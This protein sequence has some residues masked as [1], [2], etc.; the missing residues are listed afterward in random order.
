MTQRVLPL[1]GAVILLTACDS[2]PEYR[3]T[4]EQLGFRLEEV[5]GQVIERPAA[6]IDAVVGSRLCPTFDGWFAEDGATYHIRSDEADD[7]WLRA[8]FEVG[9]GPGAH[10]E[11]DAC[12]VLDAAGATSMSLRPQAC[13]LTDDGV[14]AFEADRLAVTS[15]AID[16][17]VLTYDDVAVRLIY[18]LHPGPAG[19]FGPRPERG[20]SEPLQVVAGTDFEVYLQPMS[21]GVAV[22]F[23]GGVASGVADGEPVAVVSTPDGSAEFRVEVDQ[24]FR[25]ELALPAGSL[26]GDEIVGV[27]ADAPQSLE[28]VVGYQPCAACDDGYGAPSYGLAIVRD[29]AGA[30]VFGA[31]VQWSTAGMAAAISSELGAYADVVAFDEPCGEG[32]VGV[33]K[34]WT[35]RASLGS[36]AAEVPVTFVCPDPEDLDRWA[37]EIV[38]G[39]H[40]QDALGCGC[41]AGGGAVAPTGLLV[42]ALGLRRR[43][44]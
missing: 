1:L 22:A 19:S 31:P 12:L 29:A 39:E 3:S 5:P 17:L 10:V 33:A 6:G 27:G 44:C 28:I 36:L 35:L 26:V 40:E 20:P 37:V 13:A 9:P 11:D 30:R 42:L 38:D 18:D 4:G 32:Q 7:G 25:V 24:R 41:T 16:D 23:T 34:D 8:C 21:A 43:R 2:P 14:I 15:H